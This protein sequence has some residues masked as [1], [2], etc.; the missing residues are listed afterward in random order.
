MF[1]DQF[2]FDLTLHATQRVNQRGISSRGL[3][4]VQ[5][6]GEWVEDGF[7]MTAR[8]M[9]DAR[10]QLKAQGRFDDLQRLD[11][12]RNVALV[13][14]SGTLVTVFRADAK[15]VRRLRAG[16]VRTVQ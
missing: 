9:K 11:H 6:F 8:A 14:S 1:A 15:R 4:L 12:L 16:H 10:A 2:A 3:Q 13:E 5:E 7:V